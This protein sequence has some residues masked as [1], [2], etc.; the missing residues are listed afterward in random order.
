[1]PTAIAMASYE[2]VEGPREMGNG[3]WIRFSVRRQRGGLIFGC[4]NLV[5]AEIQKGRKFR[6]IS[7]KT[8]PRRETGFS[9]FSENSRR[10]IFPCFGQ[11]TDAGVMVWM[12]MTNAGYVTRSLRQRIICWSTAALQRPF[13]GTPS[14]PWT[15]FAHF[16]NQCR[17]ISGGIISGGSRINT[18]R[19]V[20]ILCSCS[21]FGRFG[22]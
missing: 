11:L 1:M 19:E 6:A 14:P 9:V 3:I 7:K 2:V 17:Y 12:R 5:W 10:E 22:K 13:G 16:T 21:F 8:G 4:T 18:R 15:A 20:F